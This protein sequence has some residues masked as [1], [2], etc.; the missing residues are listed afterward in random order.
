MSMIF[1][2]SIKIS[3]A[4]EIPQL[5]TCNS[6]YFTDYWAEQNEFIIVLSPQG[7]FSD[8]EHRFPKEITEL[9]SQASIEALMAHDHE[10]LLVNQINSISSVFYNR[11]NELL[12]SVST[13]KNPSCSL[14]ISNMREIFNKNYIFSISY[15]SDSQNFYSNNNVTELNLSNDEFLSLISKNTKQGRCNIVYEG[16]LNIVKVCK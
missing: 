1:F 3:M 9:I 15:S 16:D 8:I 6:V 2:A 7:F 4:L 12:M 14:E 10:K 13:E 5:E 11:L